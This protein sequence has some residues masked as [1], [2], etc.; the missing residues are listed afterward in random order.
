MCPVVPYSDATW[1]IFTSCLPSCVLSCHTLYSV[2]GKQNSSSKYG[3]SLMTSNNKM[4]VFDTE[5]KNSLLLLSKEHLLN[6]L[7]C[8]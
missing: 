2:A 6:L 5:L 4:Y 3:T 7:F 8:G 1:W